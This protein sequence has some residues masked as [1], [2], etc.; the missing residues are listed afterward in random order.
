MLTLPLSLVA[1]LHHPRF[2]FFFLSVD[3]VERYGVGEGAEIKTLACE[4]KGT[5]EREKKPLRTNQFTTVLEPSRQM[6]AV[7]VF[8]KLCMLG[9]IGS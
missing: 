7:C 4:S 9:T 6:R 3:N 2:F 8:R 5:R 1:Q